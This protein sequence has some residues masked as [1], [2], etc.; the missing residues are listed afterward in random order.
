MDESVRFGRVAGI[1]VG[2]NWSVLVVLWLLCWS[3]A[4][5]YLPEADPGHGRAAY[6]AAGIVAAVVFLASLL[7]HELGHALVARRVGVGVEGI[8][9]W[10]F[11]G[12]SKLDA[13]ASTPEA[14]LRIAVVGPGVSF[15]LAG[16]FGLVAL[17]ADA[18]AAPSLV[19]TVAWW[20]AL[21]NVILAVFNLIPAAPL[22]GGRVLRA[23]WWMRKGDR[24]EATVAATRSGRV[25]GYLLIA[26]GVLEFAAGAGIGGIWFVFLGWFLLSAAQAEFRH[27]MLVDA[28]GDVRVADL[29]TAGPVTV[30]A[31]MTVQA[32]LDEVML[33]HHCSAFP[34]VTAAG[35]TVGLVTLGHVRAVEPARREGTTVGEVATPLDEVVVASAGDPAPDLVARLQ[36]SRDGRALVF[37]SGTLV[38]IVT[39]TDVMRASDVAL[40][41]AAGRHPRTTPQ[42]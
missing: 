12:V 2:A 37:E 17:G 9:L 34:V 40:V 20:L 8:T 35:A 18:I 1:P 13:E 29:M 38:G 22:D 3:L 28:L 25:F 42:P 32:L 41:A 5:S 19:A 39:P 14:E 4:A 27:A 10:L 30:A 7:A 16:L 36:G 15:A 23:W 24:L 31:E 33:S 11:G 21:I 6:W 26:V